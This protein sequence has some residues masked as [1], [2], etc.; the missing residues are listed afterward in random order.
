MRRLLKWILRVVLILVALVVVLLCFKDSILRVVIEHRIRSETGMGV[1]IGRYS[2][3]L[4]SPVVT[5]EDLKLYN[6]AEFG[7]TPFL[8]LAELHVELDAR[9]LAR[10]KLHVSL[11][12]FN[13]A[14]LNIVRNEAGKTNLFTIGKKLRL[15]TLKKALPRKAFGDFEFTGVDV[16][17]LTLGKARFIDMKDANATCE[18]DLNLRSQMFTNIRTQDDLNGVLILLYLR[19]GGNLCFIP[20]ESIQGFLSEKWG[21][22]KSRKRPPAEATAAPAPKAD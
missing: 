15:R 21:G 16:L 12:R 7:G 18:N 2:S 13:L 19:S 10:R 5:I 3:G 4:F 14:E 20:R 8:E 17:N 22:T 1:S 6:T 9:E 11:L